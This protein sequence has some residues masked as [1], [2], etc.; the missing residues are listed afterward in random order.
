[1]LIPL[2]FLETSI[3]G[4]RDFGRIWAFK[5]PSIASCVRK[6]TEAYLTLGTGC[7]PL[8][9]F[10]KTVSAP[11]ISCKL[12]MCRVIKSECLGLKPRSDGFP[13]SQ[14]GR[15]T[16][17]DWSRASLTITHCR[18]AF[19]QTLCI[20]NAIVSTPIDGYVGIKFMAFAP[21]YGYVRAKR[22]TPQLSFSPSLSF[23]LSCVPIAFCHQLAL[24]CPCPSHRLPLS[25]H[26]VWNNGASSCR[27]HKS[28]IS[29]HLLNFLFTVHTLSPYIQRLRHN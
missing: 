27:A 10:Q 14:P 26:N 20:Y 5:D 16:T 8:Y 21:N 7:P 29:F 24:P 1:M 22:T 15:R 12:C 11:I 23:L 2:F 4:A 3:Y 6:G 9:C 13:W 19:Q 17:N 25:R 28:S 18:N